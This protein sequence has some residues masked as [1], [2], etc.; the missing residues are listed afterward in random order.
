MRNLA[1]LMIISATAAI[2]QPAPP[3]QPPFELG[4]VYLSLM[5]EP[6]RTTTTKEYPFRHWFSR[7][8]RDEDG[9]V[10]RLEFHQ[11][12][13]RFFATLDVDNDRLI[14]ADEISRYEKVVAPPMIRAAGSAAGGSRRRPGPSARERPPAGPGGAHPPPMDIASIPQ[15]LAMADINFDRRVTTQEFERAA[16]R[17]FTNYDADKDGKLTAKELRPSRTGRP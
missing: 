3:K 17:R 1:L 7:A 12:A 5:G 2:A 4:S 15:P 14:D 16:S 10:S 11:D 9:A 6:F 8:D 13:E